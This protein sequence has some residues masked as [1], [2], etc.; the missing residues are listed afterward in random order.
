MI[1]FDILGHLKLSHEKKYLTSGMKNFTPKLAIVE[2]LETICKKGSIT[3]HI[4]SHFESR[5]SRKRKKTRF[6]THFPPLQVF[7]WQKRK[8]EEEEKWKE[9]SKSHRRSPI[10]PDGQTEEE[11]KKK[12]WSVTDG[13]FRKIHNQQLVLAPLQCSGTRELRSA[14]DLL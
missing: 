6:K 14:I 10:C 5:N 2:N 4:L 12:A 1:N 3:S 8:E 9:G 7:K 13:H 11:R